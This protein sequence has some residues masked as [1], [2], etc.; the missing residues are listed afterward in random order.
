MA[1]LLFLPDLSDHV[2]N[3]V[4]LAGAVPVPNGSEPSSHS[5]KLEKLVGA[6]TELEY[7]AAVLNGWLVGKLL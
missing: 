4:P 2:V 1:A 5:C 3:V 6:K 7:G